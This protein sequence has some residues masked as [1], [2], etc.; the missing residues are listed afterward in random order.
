M[1]ELLDA[2]DALT[3][4]V[5]LHHTIADSRFT[6]IVTDTPLLTRLQDEIRFSLSREGSKS[7]PNQRVP[8]NSGALMLFMR[9]SSQVTDWANGAGS[10]VVKG[11]PGRTLRGWYVAWVQQ[12]RG[13]GEV[14][15]RVR[16]LHGWAAAI[17]REL[18]PPRM[19]D[20]PDPCPA[21][22]AVEWWR[23]GERYPR[24]LVVESPRNP[25][26]NLIDE[27]TATCR[28]CD[29]RWG[30]RELAYELEQKAET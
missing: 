1:T 28:A 20:L 5:I 2:V 7:L 25:E 26:K 13:D 30:A 4:P 23:D 22:G 24:P 3:K 17:R 14:A 29:K 9:I 15:A 10:G 19:K 6:C 12:V 21:C 11:D 27:S 8:L 16:I 18:D